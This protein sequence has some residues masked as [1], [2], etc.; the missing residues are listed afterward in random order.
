M[1]SN[2]AKRVTQII[3]L[4]LR[5]LMLISL[6]SQVCDKRLPRRMRVEPSFHFSNS[7]KVVSPKTGNQNSAALAAMLLVH[8]LLL[9]RRGENAVHVIVKIATFERVPLIRIKPDTVTMDA[10]IESKR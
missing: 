3:N 1:S 5:W 2:A 4:R 7:L 10:S 8:D 9:P 6:C